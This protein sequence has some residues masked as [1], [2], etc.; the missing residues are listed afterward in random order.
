[1]KHKS[2]LFQI[3]LGAFILIFGIHFLVQQEELTMG[4]TE[5]FLNFLDSI[6]K[7]VFKLLKNEKDKKFFGHPFTVDLVYITTLFLGLH[8]LGKKFLKNI[9]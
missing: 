9:Y 8:F 6:L 7:N 1:M 5:S 2:E 3:I 4:G